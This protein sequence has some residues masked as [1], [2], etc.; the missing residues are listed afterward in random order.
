M[1]RSL[2]GIGRG[3]SGNSS[4]G[5]DPHPLRGG[6]APA[7]VTSRAPATR[8]LEAKP[9]IP[10]ARKRELEQ[11]KAQIQITP[12]TEISFNQLEQLMDV[13]HRAQ[14]TLKLALRD[15]PDQ[16]PVPELCQ[17]L[18][19]WLE[20]LDSSL[21]GPAKAGR[22]APLREASRTCLPLLALSKEKLESL[23]L[24]LS[25]LL[26]SRSRLPFPPDQIDAAR[27]SLSSVTAK[28][29]ERTL[30]LGGAGALALG[31]MQ[32]IC[33]M[34]RR[35]VVAGMLDADHA[36][37][38]A[39]RNFCA[40]V[41]AHFVQ[42]ADKDHSFDSPHD[43]GKCASLIEMM[44]D[45]KL[46]GVA[47][48]KREKDLARVLAWLV[49]PSALSHIEQDSAA[50]SLVGIDNLVKR[51][52]ECGK[53]D[54][55]DRDLDP[56]WERLLHA[57]CSL[58]AKAQVDTDGR[59][60]SGFVNLLRTMHDSDL[61]AQWKT[62]PDP[63][64]AAPAPALAARYTK[65][66]RHLVAAISD[67]A[68]DKVGDLQTVS[69]LI[70]GVKS[71][72]KQ[73]RQGWSPE[74]QWLGRGELEVA[75][76]RLLSA[77]PSANLNGL[78]DPKTVGALFS[79]LGYLWQEQLLGA[80]G[81]ALDCLLSLL[82]PLA[83]SSDWERRHVLG[84]LPPLMH[85]LDQQQ[86]DAQRLQP[87]FNALLGR[88]TGGWDRDEVLVWS[89]R[90]PPPPRPA[91]LPLVVQA[92]A[93]PGPPKASEPRLVG[94]TR[95]SQVQPLA[96][97]PPEP[98]SRNLPSVV[99][100]GAWSPNWEADADGFVQLRGRA[101]SHTTTTTTATT[102]T[103]TTTTT[104][105]TTRPG[106]GTSTTT[107]T[108]TTTRPGTGTAT[109]TTAATFTTTT[110]SVTPK[111]DLPGAVRDEWLR[112]VTLPN[113]D[114]SA[115]LVTL[116]KRHPEC[117]SLLDPQGRD[118]FWLLF[119]SGK[120][121]SLGALVDDERIQYRPTISKTRRK[122][123]VR[124]LSASPNPTA[125]L[126]MAKLFALDAPPEAGL[127][128]PEANR[129]PAP[130]PA[131]AERPPAS[132]LNPKS[133]I[134]FVNALYAGEVPA[135]SA[136]L[137]RN[138]DVGMDPIA[139]GSMLE[140][141]VASGQVEVLR[142]L[143][144]RESFGALLGQKTT[145][146]DSLLHIALKAVSAG[147]LSLVGAD[148]SQ[149]RLRAGQIVSVLLEAPAVRAR[150][151]V[152]NLEGQNALLLAVTLKLWPQVREMLGYPEFQ[153]HVET[154]SNG[155][156]LL[157][158]VLMAGQ[159]DLLQLLFGPPTQRQPWQQAICDAVFTTFPV[160]IEVPFEPSQGSAYPI[161]GISHTREHDVILQAVELGQRESLEPLLALPTVQARLQRDQD[162]KDVLLSLAKD[163]GHAWIVERV[164]E[165]SHTAGSS[166]G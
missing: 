110:T 159:S 91:P 130:R 86:V 73:R 150:A 6:A 41:F 60:L 55:R 37:Q 165:L 45:H 87:V 118:T 33:N 67:P 90:A 153:A 151:C 35:L 94:E 71:A 92:G 77:L 105:T 57:M 131:P 162:W 28:L 140:A 142:M 52:L 128:P 161:A 88:R 99:L 146:D 144:A 69:N 27:A 157:V 163:E 54:V 74:E 81:K 89:R 154:G 1:R 126:L 103:P 83:A 26:N 113:A 79:G 96:S 30:A 46:G 75:A 58:N 143:L 127:A 109:T 156:H 43:L 61:I 24:G 65:T 76:E 25:A 84:L 139:R 115:K 98:A 82:Q 13:L 129:D 51:L 85:L 66:Y 36:S 148:V 8:P 22:H 70:S 117:L 32:N 158:Q 112:L 134:D 100:H 3:H 47:D 107:T 78:R 4:R 12:I 97:L 141:A 119:T 62:A 111:R 108:T 18:L 135:L 114:P 124:L 40:Q 80:R 10:E 64:Q 31:Q 145:F 14:N 59:P 48:A 95:L 149:K 2:A 122:E 11:L 155:H 137:Q 20:Q 21:Q 125:Q 44:F 50:V 104:T 68:F 39:T 166:S 38:E 42:W 93:L 160:R 16:S 101:P 106:R 5:A 123:L 29:M 138:I 164:Q 63:A 120:L 7:S 34:V 136:Q 147:E 19:W 121:K 102:P 15:Y 133:W 49:S 53:L 72:E 56:M 116:V 17:K 23:C 132:I 9:A 152:L